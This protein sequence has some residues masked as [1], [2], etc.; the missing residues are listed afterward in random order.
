M[1]FVPAGGA[2]FPCGAENTRGNSKKKENGRE[3]GGDVDRVR[4][5]GESEARAKCRRW[6]ESKEE[7]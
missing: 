7:R 6:I 1:E 2:S 5:G 4:L 3:S